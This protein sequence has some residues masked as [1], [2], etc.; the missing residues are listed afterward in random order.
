MES[1]KH[2]IEDLT[3]HFNTRMAEFQKSLQGS[4]PATSPNS[5][6]AAQFNTF[7]VFVLS[8]LEGLQMQVE[9]LSKQYNQLEMRSRR[10]MLLFHGVPEDKKEN[11]PVI[12]SGVISGHLKVPEF[13]IEKLS[14]CQRLGHSSRDKPRP[15]LVKFRDVVLRNKIWYSK[16]SLKS[17]GVTLSEFLTKERHDLFMSARQKFGISKC[18]T[19]DGVVI[20]TGSDGKRHRIVTTAE[21][22]SINCKPNYMPSATN[23]AAAAG[24]STVGVDSISKSSN[25]TQVMRSK[26]TVKK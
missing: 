10:K 5:N 6:I 25:S 24:T 13:T 18:W 16:T 26:R 8:A 19:K 7:R 14:R 3:E 1:I 15:I 12:V 17:T 23:L 9:I 2:S 21:L 11:L 22:N 4:I 20:V